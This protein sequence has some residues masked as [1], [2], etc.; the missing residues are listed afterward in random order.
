MPVL[1]L[2]RRRSGANSRLIVQGRFADR[3]L[4]TR[5]W[6]NLEEIA[7]W[8]AAEGGAFAMSEAKKK[9]VLDAIVRDFLSGRF[10]SGGRS[11]VLFLHPYAGRKRL[12]ARWADPSRDGAKVGHPW[13]ARSRS[14][15]IEA[16]DAR[17]YFYVNNRVWIVALFNGKIIARLAVP[18]LRGRLPRPTMLPHETDWRRGL[19]VSVRDG[20]DCAEVA[21]CSVDA[22]LDS[23]DHKCSV[24]PSGREDPAT[25]SRH[26]RTPQNQEYPLAGIG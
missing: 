17:G 3:Q 14:I 21:R 18:P 25:P 4:H 6:I 15:K 1:D 13:L 7:D 20:G 10:E 5:D 26:K 22:R 8:V 2:Q 19:V 24:A 16:D 23:T 9:R 12:I 11:K